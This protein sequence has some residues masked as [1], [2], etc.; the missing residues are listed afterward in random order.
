MFAGEKKVV[1]RILFLNSSM[2]DSSGC[3]H[4]SDQFPFEALAHSTPDHCVTLIRLSERSDLEISNLT[5]LP[6][7]FL[8][9]LATEVFSRPDYCEFDSP[10]QTLQAAVANSRSVAPAPGSDEVFL[11]SFVSNA[12]CRMAFHAIAAQRVRLV[13]LCLSLPVW[14]LCKEE[15]VATLV[16]TLQMSTEQVRD[17]LV[18]SILIC[19]YHYERSQNKS[20]NA[21]SNAADGLPLGLHGGDKWCEDLFHSL[22]AFCRIEVNACIVARESVFHII[23]RCL[24]QCRT[25]GSQRWCITAAANLCLADNGRLLF[26]RSEFVTACNWLS[27]NALHADVD[28]WLATCI[29]NILYTKQQP[30]SPRPLAAPSPLAICREAFET[31][32]VRDMLIRMANTAHARITPSASDAERDAVCHAITSCFSALVNLAINCHLAEPESRLDLCVTPEMLNLILFFGT[33]STAEDVV[34]MVAALMRIMAASQVCKQSFSCKSFRD[35]FIRLLTRRT[36]A[37]VK[38]KVLGALVLLFDNNPVSFA[39]NVAL[40]GDSNFRT[41]VLESHLAVSLSP[42]HSI[43][44]LSILDS[45]DTIKRRCP[46]RRATRCFFRTTNSFVVSNS[47]T[48]WLRG[49]QDFLPKNFCRRIPLSPRRPLSRGT[50][51]PGAFVTFRFL[52]RVFRISWTASFHPLCCGRCGCC[53]SPLM[54]PNAP[55]DVFQLRCPGESTRVLLCSVC[56]SVFVLHLWMLEMLSFCFACF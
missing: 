39:E 16:E 23:M 22:A 37:E 55:E 36:R 43:E 19:C 14:G 34:D 10:S 49:F 26:V 11:R 6:L 44:I 54:D 28:R 46:S 9:A 8:I 32:L 1:V 50:P 30:R 45:V 53:L 51:K 38:V 33:D 3:H 29:M 15:H 13:E 4:S 31:P 41:A 5:A 40:F 25:P 56:K 48:G 47:W 35:M 20:C 7:N 24:P 52:A 12:H 21:Q 42:S 18:S 2:C 27:R 17:E